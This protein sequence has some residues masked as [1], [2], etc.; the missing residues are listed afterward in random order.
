MGGSVRFGHFASIG[1]ALCFAFAAT[2]SA[3]AFTR[4]QAIQD[5]KRSAGRPV[6]LACM[7]G[8]GANHG[9]CFESARPAVRQCVRNKWVHSPQYHRWCTMATGTYQN[10][11][12]FAR[13]EAAGCFHAPSPDQHVNRL[14]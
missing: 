8:A 2:G 13:R 5:C 4:E 10:D 14:H 11:K 12:S 3:A 1:I 7:K 9:A 6:Y